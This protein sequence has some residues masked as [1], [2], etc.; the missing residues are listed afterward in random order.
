[1]SYTLALERE[2]DGAYFA[3]VPV[4]PGCVSQGDARH[5]AIRNIRDAT[6]AYIDDCVAAGDPAP[7]QESVELVE[8][9]L[10]P[11]PL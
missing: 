5:E 6:E 2:P 7:K 10:S 11:D 8:L 1:M 4:L 3:S 9:S